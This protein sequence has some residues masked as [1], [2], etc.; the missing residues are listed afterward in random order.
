MD[1]LSYLYYK[2]LIFTGLKRYQ[3]AI[4][5]FSLVI[6]YPANCTH[7]VHCESYKK[8]IILNLMVNGKIPSLPKQMN[9]M[10][11]YKL[12]NSFLLY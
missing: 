2:G 11:K 9:Q 12:E 6:S 3:E 1:I 8:L 5:Q 10:L 7:K 4:N